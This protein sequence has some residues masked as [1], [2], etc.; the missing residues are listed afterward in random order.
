MLSESF[1]FLNIWIILHYVC[2]AYFHHPFI[3]WNLSRLFPFPGYCA[4]RSNEYGWV[5]ISIIKYLRVLCIELEVDSYSTF[6]DT[7]ILIS[8]VPVPLYTPMGSEKV[9][10]F[11]Q[12]LVMICWNVSLIL[13]IPAGIRWN[14]K[15][16]LLC[17][18]QKGKD[19]QHFKKYFS[20]ICVLY[21]E[22]SLFSSTPH[23]F[24]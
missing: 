8:S 13:A 11:L 22:N 6:W 24:F 23:F 1:I 14:L 9:F 2:L 3:N 21:F 16:V 17:I 15:V 18:S 19:A 12:I 4:T 5:G 7:S 20:A 10:P